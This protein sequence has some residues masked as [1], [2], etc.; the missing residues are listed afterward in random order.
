MES[1]GVY[2]NCLICHAAITGDTGWWDLN[3]EKCLACQKA[4]ENGVVPGSICANRDSWYATYDLVN[5]FK[6]SPSTI[7]IMI[8]EGKLKSRKIK[9]ISGTTS[10][11]LFL[12][13]ENDMLAIHK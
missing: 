6:I 3:G 7:T 9:A 12:K 2:Y 5:Q 13:Q 8:K 10:F 4:V 1:N 11:E